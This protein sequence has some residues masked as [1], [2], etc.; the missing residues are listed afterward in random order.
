MDDMHNRGVCGFEFEEL[1][2]IV[3]SVAVLLHIHSTWI[4]EG[5]VVNEG[6]R[7][8]RL[9]IIADVGGGEDLHM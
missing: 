8:L 7:H 9:V 4:P 3:C 5:L 1:A 6:T 2:G